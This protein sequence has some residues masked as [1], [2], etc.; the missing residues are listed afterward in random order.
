[1]C[2]EAHLKFSGQRYSYAALIGHA[3]LATSFDILLFDG[4]YVISVDK[5]AVAI[6]RSF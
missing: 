3:S 5:V 6:I 2:K 1:M 4:K